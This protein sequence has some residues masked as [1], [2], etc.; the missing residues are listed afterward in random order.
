M[1]SPRT[2]RVIII[3]ALL[4][5][6]VQGCGRQCGIA[7]QTVANSTLRDPAGVTLATVGMLLREYVGPRSFTVAINVDIPINGTD[8]SLHGHVV[9]ARWVSESGELLSELETTPVGNVVV[10]LLS[11]ETSNAEFLRLRQAVLTTHTRL[12]LDTDLPGREH[13]VAVMSDV[14]H[15]S[16]DAPACPGL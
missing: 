13:L 15:V 3:A 8:A 5:L 1:P 6:S 16:L 11:Q 9:R 2:P 14:Q 12:L 4:L 7:D 10:A